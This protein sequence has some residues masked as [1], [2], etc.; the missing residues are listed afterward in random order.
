[1]GAHASRGKGLGFANAGYAV[2]VIDNPEASPAAWA[3]RIVDA[4]PERFD[5]VPATAVVR[6]GAHVIAIAVRQEGMHA[7]ALVRYPV[8]ALARCD[9]AAGEWWAGDARGWVA[10]GSL[11][12]PGPAWVLDDAGSE[13]SVHW[14]ER[15][16]SFV[17]VASYGFGAST[18]GLRT[19][20][21]LT[22]PWSAP[23]AVFRPAE[24]D[25]QRPFVYAA[26]AHPELRGPHAA[27]LVVTYASN[28]F[29]FADLLTMQGERSLYWPRFVAVPI[30]R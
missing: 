29:E 12:G 26:R 6:D 25:G 4:A 3:P 7:G 15:T 17:H 8:A 1:V 18:I 16:R 9:V 10:V 23:V 27:D 22:G 24:S 11:G 21:S 5:A 20:P 14:D 2:A 28:S 19:A 30:G 13:C